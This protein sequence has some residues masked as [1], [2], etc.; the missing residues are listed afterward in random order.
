MVESATVDSIAKLALAE[1]PYEL[2]P[3]L[4]L[5]QGPAETSG[6]VDAGHL[7]GIVSGMQPQ[8]QSDVLNSLLFAQLAA[9][10]QHDRGDFQN[11][12]PVYKDVL[13]KCG[14]V[15]G[16]DEI[17][18]YVAGGS[19]FTINDVVLEIL[20]GIAT[21]GQLAA[22]TAAI[23]ALKSLATSDHRLQL[24][25]QTTH[26]ASSGSLQVGAATDQGGSI[27]V[28]SAI[29]NFSTTQTITNVLW[30]H[31]AKDE[32]KLYRAAGGMTL[33][34]DVYSRLRDTIVNK[35]GDRATKYIA[36]LPLAN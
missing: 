33:N 36:D 4:I 23:T 13:S 32:T 29:L 26:R 27:A 34:P 6:A 14:W 12:Y 31:F 5:P 22:I 21:P 15:I 17:T 7:L 10:A 1:L 24:W 16:A 3:S 28:S 19:S 30:F 2:P 25:D 8:N 20:A 9:T 11:W 35:L 18:R